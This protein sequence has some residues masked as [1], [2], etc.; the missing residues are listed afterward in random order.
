MAT[1]DAIILAADGLS[2]ACVPAPEADSR[3]RGALKPK[4]GSR[5]LEGDA[6]EGESLNCST[7]SGIGLCMTMVR[8][9]HYRVGHRGRMD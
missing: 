5:V 9:Q 3:D 2:R 6:N 8:G 4:L 7:R 1:Y